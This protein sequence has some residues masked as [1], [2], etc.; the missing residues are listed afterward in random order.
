MPLKMNT[1]MLIRYKNVF[2]AIAVSKTSQNEAK[3]CLSKTVISGQCMASS[4]FAL[5]RFT[6]LNV[7]N[8]ESQKCVKLAYFCKVEHTNL[9][10]PV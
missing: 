2:V 1:D 8:N 10:E 7:R 3:L 4:F 5:R 6:L 9:P